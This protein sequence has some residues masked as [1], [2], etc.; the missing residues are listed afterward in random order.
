[1]Q[2]WA[3]EVASIYAE[4]TEI[5]DVS[6]LTEHLIG[7]ARNPINI[8]VAGRED[9]EQIFFLTDIQV[10]NILFKRYV[11]GSF[12]SI[13]E[14]Q[15][16]D[17]LPV[18][19]IQRLEPLLSFGPHESETRKFRLW[20]DSFLRAGFQLEKAKGFEEDDSG[21]LYQGD[22][23]K[24][25]KRTQIETNRNFSAGMIVEKDPGEP[26]FGKGING[27][28]L[29][30]GYVHYKKEN[31]WFREALAGRYFA[32]AAQGLVLQ[33]GMPMR[34]SSMTTSIRNR[35]ASFRP[36][37]S[38]SEAMAMQG[39]YAVLG[40]KSVEVIP[41][42]SQNYRDGRIDG[43]GRLTSLREDGFHRTETEI[44]QRHNVLELV[45]G[46]KASWSGRWLNLEAGHVNYRLDRSLEPNVL[47]YNQ[48]YFR[49]KE[50]ANS[51]L[52][53]MVSRKNLLLF[54]EVASNELSHYAFY[55]G[56]VWGA[57]PGFSLS[58]SQRSISTQYK[59]PLAGPMTESGSFQGEEGYYCGIRWEFPFQIILSS[60]LDYY[61]FHWLKFRIDAPA[62]GSD[63]LGHLEKDFGQDA[64]LRIKFRHREKPV[65][66]GDDSPEEGICFQKYDQLKV[67]YRQKVNPGWQLTSLAQWHFVRNEGENQ[68]GQMVAQDL[69][70]SNENQ[71]LTL[72]GRLAVFSTTGYE[73]RLYSYEPH[74]LYM[75][76]VP[77]YAGKGSRFLLMVNYKVA[78]SLHFWLRAARWQYSDRAEIG[79]GSQQI[80]S[81]KKTEFTFQ[82]RLKF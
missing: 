36:S 74:V 45:A 39:G 47:P 41:F 48:F 68:N 73:A 21:V 7:L 64:T 3:E 33:S 50:N 16:V 59:A 60:Y 5:E 38:A 31:G 1:M 72:T 65:N 82:M 80:A 17:G 9:L 22:R 79:S 67:Q 14:L 58:L 4:E 61:R 35:R 46:A 78:R 40:Y 23:F 19:V 77:A 55:N 71:T 32:S 24:L 27:I 63:W 54:G 52:G 51:W 49:G 53:Y 29:M 81:N 56:L 44:N 12:L 2:Q 26:M 30:S 28:D 6:V 42:Y 62:S 15:A 37:L 66:E 25:Y 70:W 8:N 18:D 13:Y 57:A 20:G 75:F 34:K 11:N 69:R 43:N 76:S 10:E